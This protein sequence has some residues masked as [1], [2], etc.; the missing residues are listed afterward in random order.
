LKICL[1]DNFRQY[2]PEMG[3]HALRV[4]ALIDTLLT[5][6]HKVTVIHAG[7]DS[8]VKVERGMRLLSIAPPGLLTS[9]L[10]AL[11]P[12]IF[13]RRGHVKDSFILNLPNSLLKMRKE[14]LDADLV[15]IEDPTLVGA[16]LLARLYNRPCIFDG[17]GITSQVERVEL[18]R[19]PRSTK[20]RSI[21]TYV[22]AIICEKIAYRFASRIVTS[23]R[24]DKEY[25]TTLH[26]I[27][28][29]KVAIVPNPIGRNE[30]RVGLH[31]PDAGFV[32]QEH[33]LSDADNVVAFVG[34]LE[35]P[36]NKEA[37][38]YIGN[39]LANDREVRESKVRFLII[40]NFGEG[41]NEW[42]KYDLIFTGPVPDVRP[43]ILA[44][45]VCIAPLMSQ[46]TGVKTK[47]LTYLSC[48]K[49]TVATGFALTGLDPTIRMFVDE[50]DL[51]SFPKIMLSRLKL[52]GKNKEPDNE[53][54]RQVMSIYSNE[55]VG[56]QY[57]RDVL[58]PL[59]ES[60][61]PSA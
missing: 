20:V 41:Q 57:E 21:V 27:D 19:G 6:G 43:Y 10:D 47:V 59:L 29:S 32:R 18:D 24:R 26:G 49:P 53:L 54:V 11:H 39:I 31:L 8:F 55:S 44:S 46:P 5:S 25:L 23:S 48:G 42:E 15:Q 51:T 40:G 52:L 2:S 28:P 30:D 50:S 56:L 38:E 12:L 61:G 9:A 36:H 16:F 4:P 33:G 1:I 34:N 17:D 45:D 37:V 3:G 14:I 7:E 58:Q 13:P 35:A 60:S 22:G